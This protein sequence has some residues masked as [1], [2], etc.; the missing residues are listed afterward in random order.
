MLTNLITHE[1]DI[2]IYIYIYKYIYTYIYIYIYLTES[3]GSVLRKAVAR[4]A[5]QP[6]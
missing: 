2:H 1:C 6:C 3:E 4:F 5:I